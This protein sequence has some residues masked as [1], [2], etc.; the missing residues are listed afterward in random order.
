MA[1][2][3]WKF[4]YLDYI[5]SG[6]KIVHETILPFTSGKIIRYILKFIKN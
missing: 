5:D 1:N 6:L 2:D 4:I 3:R